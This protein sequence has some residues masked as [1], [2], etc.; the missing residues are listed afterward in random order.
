MKKVSEMLAAKALKKEQR[1]AEREA[2]GTEQDGGVLTS[3]IARSTFAVVL[4]PIAELVRSFASEEGRQRFRARF[5]AKQKKLLDS[6]DGQIDDAWLERAA[7]FL[8]S[9]PA[10]RGMDAR[11]ITW[12]EWTEFGAAF[13]FPE[14][15]VVRTLQLVFVL[16]AQTAQAK[17]EQIAARNRA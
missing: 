2:Q 5:S 1:R 10:G 6:I 15:D 16:S 9:I 3:K 12:A 14:D 13:G 17:A 7:D 4:P 11:R 8:T